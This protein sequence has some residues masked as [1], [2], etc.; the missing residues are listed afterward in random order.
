MKDGTLFPWQQ[1]KGPK[2]TYTEYKGGDNRAAALV[3]SM[4]SA[5]S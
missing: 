3:F 1:D 4:S 5:K 2:K